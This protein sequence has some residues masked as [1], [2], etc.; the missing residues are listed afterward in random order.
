MYIKLKFVLICFLSSCI[1]VVSYAADKNSKRVNELQVLIDVSGSMKKN[2]PKNL[3]IPA[4]K[5]LINLLPDGSKVGLWLFSEKTSELVKMGRVNKQWKQKALLKIKK[6]HSRGLLTNIEEAIGQ[7]AKE[8]LLSPSQQNR[9]LIILTDGMV[10]TSKDIMQ[11]A[12]SRARIM[13]Q[14]VPLLQQAGIKVQTIALSKDADAELLGKLATG[15]GGWSETAQS[16]DQ[17][18]KVFFK[19]FKQAIPQDTTPLVGNAFTIDKAIKEFSVLIFKQPGSKHPQLMTPGNKK[20][21]HKSRSSK[22]SWLS[23]KNYDLVTIKKPK[24]GLWRIIGNIDPD[25]QVMIVTD[26]KFELDEIPTHILFKDSFNVSGF[27]TNQQ[28]LIT[29]SD[30]LQLIDLSIF[31]E[32]G[33]R[34]KMTAVSGKQGLFSKTLGAELKP[35]RHTLKIIADGQTFKREVTRVIEVIDSLIAVKKQVD[36]ILHKVTIEL[37]PNSIAINTD[38]MTIEASISQLGKQTVK[39]VLEKKSGQWK[40]VVNEPETG[41]SKIVNFSVIANTPQGKS[42]SPVILPIVVNTGL[43]NAAKPK[44]PII[45]LKKKKTKKPAKIAD[46]IEAEV[47]DEADIDKVEAE[48]VNWVKTIIII[49]IINIILIAIGFFAYKYVK[50]Q[51][52]TKQDQLLSRLD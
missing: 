34:F 12:E 33:Q 52:A 25:N 18:Q 40:L 7:S 1:C 24:V 31:L 45:K 16:A 2:D 51:S 49:L 5:L 6:I 10:D 26:L 46:K 9:S 37:I 27:F 22:V 50:K 19:L 47:E 29:R 42:I 21:N 28:Q 14:Q 32:D 11:S 35:G 44:V 48:P 41:A 23:E 15:T 8:W 17:L 20:I 13:E 36:S 39:Q 30:F 43:F 38:M 4:I 3:R